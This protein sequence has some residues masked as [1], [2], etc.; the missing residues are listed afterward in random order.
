MRGM[1]AVVLLALAGAVLNAQS[2]PRVRH[3]GRFPAD[4]P[5][6]SGGWILKPESLKA[7]PSAQKC[8]EPGQGRCGLVEIGKVGGSSWY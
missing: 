1:T 2:P 5:Q 6:N 3:L 8:A 7:L 4:L